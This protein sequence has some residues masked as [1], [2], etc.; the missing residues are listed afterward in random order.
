[1]TEI[2]FAAFWNCTSL[3]EI[4]VEDG[5]STLYWGTYGSYNSYFDECP[6][7]KVYLGRNLGFLG[8]NYGWFDYGNR[9]SSLTIGN[10]VTT[11]CDEVFWNLAQD[12]SIY[13][14]CTTPPTIEERSD[15]AYVNW[16][17]YVPQGTLDAYQNA[18][19]WKEFWN[20]QEHNLTGVS[21]VSA[22]DIA[23]EVTANG[24]ALSDTD[25][26]AVAV[27]TVAGAL[28]EKIDSYAGEEIALDKGVYVLR[29]G[30]KTM[31]VKL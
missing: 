20:I 25:G 23:I 27:Y 9:I 22:G 14:M 13:L 18:N 15:A 12:I 26:K 29:I 11:I 28:V 17:I 10:R 16:N 7:E 19:V 4:C 1:M 24:I 31:K 2:N 8:N 30:N 6:I 21:E 3:K 5:T